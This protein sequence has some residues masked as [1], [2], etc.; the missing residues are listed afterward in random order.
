[1]VDDV[2]SSG[3][4]RDSRVAML[5]AMSTEYW[6]GQTPFTDRRPAFLGLGH[7]YFKPYLVNEDQL[8]QGAL[9][10]YDALYVMD[11]Y[12]SEKAQAKINRGR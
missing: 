6:G 10:H 1:M 4:M 3:V 2:L 11:P 12:V 5:W 9:D 7:E 8:L